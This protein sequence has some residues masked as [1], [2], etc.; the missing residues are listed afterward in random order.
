MTMTMVTIALMVLFSALLIG[1]ILM[2]M[3]PESGFGAGRDDTAEDR[4]PAE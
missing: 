3:F 4:T 2:E 1:K